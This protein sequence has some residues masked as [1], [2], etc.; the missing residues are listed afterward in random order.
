MAGGRPVVAF[1]SRSP[2]ILSKFFQDITVFDWPQNHFR[3]GLRCLP[4]LIVLIVCGLAFDR[5]LDCAIAAAGAMSVGFGSFQRLRKSRI[6]V[7]LAVSLGI[8]IAAGTG[9]LASR[10][11]VAVAVVVS[12]W[13][14]TYGL[15]TAWE[16]GLSWMGLQCV[17]V[18]AIASG[19]AAS[20]PQALWRG[21]L[22]T[23]GGLLQAAIIMAIW[24]V[25]GRPHEAG[26]NATIGTGAVWH[27]DLRR[28]VSVYSP[29]GRYAFQLGLTLAVAAVTYRLLHLPNGYWVPMTAAI[30]LKPDFDHTFSRGLARLSGTLFGVFLSAALAAFLP[31][32]PVIYTALIVL[33]AWLSYSLIKVNYA[34]FAVSITC[35]VTLL[36]ALA[37]FPILPV[38]RAR[39][40]DT[41]LAGL[42]SLLVYLLPFPKEPVPAETGL[43][44]S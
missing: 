5:R 26:E 17:I 2:A 42:L 3:G 25:L 34:L 13:A 40:L 7:M 1:H 41:A 31:H 39:L 35:Y 29:I 27:E 16:A 22:T 36:L 44:P 33:F 20:P 30:I 23:S 6:R 21:V 18:A 10:S 15:L 11:D 4:G 38:V 43:S 12:G 8:G 19:V 28:H 24:R 14:F 37:G 32:G 9:S